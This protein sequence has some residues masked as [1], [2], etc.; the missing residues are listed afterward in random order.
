MRLQLASLIK[1]LAKLIGLCDFYSPFYRRTLTRSWKYKNL[2]K[3]ALMNKINFG[4]TPLRY[5]ILGILLFKKNSRAKNEL[6][7]LARV[8]E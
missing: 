4:H 1:L 8:L 5:I 3:F 2:F 7:C 6:L